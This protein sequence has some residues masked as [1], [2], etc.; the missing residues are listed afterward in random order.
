MSVYHTTHPAWETETQTTGTGLQQPE[1]PAASSGHL[2]AST[3]TP[4]PQCPGSKAQAHGHSAAPWQNQKNPKTQKKQ[5][6]E[7]DVNWSKHSAG[8]QIMTEV[9]DLGAMCHNVYIHLPVKVYAACIGIG[10][11]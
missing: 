6:G 10:D 4:A 1:L 2:T 5:S 3:T 8:T 7:W 9:A 11:S